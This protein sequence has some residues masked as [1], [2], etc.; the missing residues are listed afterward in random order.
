MGTRDGGNG[1]RRRERFREARGGFAVPPYPRKFPA[2]SNRTRQIDGLRVGVIILKEA[3]RFR[4][5]RKFRIGRPSGPERSGFGHIHPVESVASAKLRDAHPETAAK[6]VAARRGSHSAMGEL[7]EDCRNYLLLVANASVGD[8]LRAKVAASDLVQEA[9]LEAGQIFDRFTGD[10]EE[11]LLRWLTRILE[12][13]VGNA[14][15]RHVRAAKRDVS[16]EVRLDQGVNGN[17]AGALPADS[18]PSPSGIAAAGEDELRLEQALA[19]LPDQY[20]QV[21]DLRVNQSLS[22]EEVGRAMDRTGE[23]ARKLF[24]RAI[25]ELRLRITAHEQSTNRN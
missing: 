15:K 20:R 18:A 5:F 17:Q 10:S 19:E 3:V 6:L 2:E 23:A 1:I 16:R 24:A 11:D 9:F 21:I 7:F 4:S 25:D 22:F 13:K 14:V 8:G 12:H